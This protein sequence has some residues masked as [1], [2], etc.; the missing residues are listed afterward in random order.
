MV[1]YGG[2]RVASKSWNRYDFLRIFIPPLAFV[3]WTMIQKATA[4]DAVYPGLAAAPRT[5]IALFGAILLGM[6]STVLAYKADQ[7]IPTPPENHKTAVVAEPVGEAL[8]AP[9]DGGH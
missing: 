2:A 6:L 4:F 7:N 5:A 1:L 3:G 8:G 9:Q